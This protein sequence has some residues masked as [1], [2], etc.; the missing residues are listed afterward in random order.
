MNN[1]IETFTTPILVSTYDENFEKEKEYVNNLDCSRENKSETENYNMQSKDTFVLKNPAL[2]KLKSFFEDRIEMYMN[3]VWGSST[4][5]IITQS[6]INKSSFGQEHQEHSHPNSILSG[7]FYFA[8]DDDMPCMKFQR[9]H[10]GNLL[11]K[12]HTLNERNNYHRLVPAKTAELILFPSDLRHSVS[13]NTSNNTRISLSF[14]T[15]A[16]ESLGS[17]NSLT[18]L[19]LT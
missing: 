3:Y 16:K 9:P 1:L 8:L 14:N 10:P 18:Y 6:W 19:P 15:F 5:L 4:E 2:S 13:R 12:Y 7:V 11:L 17:I